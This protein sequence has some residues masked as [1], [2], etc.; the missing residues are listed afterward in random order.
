[1]P[2]EC[3][4]YVVYLLIHVNPPRFW[5]LDTPVHSRG[6]VQYSAKQ[7]RCQGGL[8]HNSVIYSNN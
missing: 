6:F 8:C 4:L 5:A 3:T 7:K 1:V 2:F